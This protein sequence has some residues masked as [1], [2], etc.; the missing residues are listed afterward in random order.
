MHAGIDW[1]RPHAFLDTE[2]QQIVR[3][4]ELGRRYADRLVQVWLPEGQ[5]AWLLIHIEVQSQEEQGFAQRMFVYYYRIFD[6]HNREVVSLAVLAD[7]RAE[8]RPYTYEQARW[9]CKLVFQYPVAKLADWRSRRQDLEESDNPFATVVLAHLA[10]QETRK[11]ADRREHAKLY[12]I[13]RLYERG[14]S[15]ERVLSLF[16]FIDWLLAL[17]PAGESRIR[18]AIEAT[19]EEQKMPYTTSIERMARE[20]G[21]EEGREAGRL[22][23]RREDI[24]QFVRAR[25]G[26]VPTALEERLATADETTLNA[27]IVRAATVSTT[28]EL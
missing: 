25:F 17:P 18:Q 22:D 21:R 20:E 10:A 5:D 6:R 3:D 11:D 19:E 1:S 27:L 4:A 24:R 9:G 23:A 14:Y 15:R 7:E 13:R 2:L 12:L 26:Q 8:W 16:R 28:D